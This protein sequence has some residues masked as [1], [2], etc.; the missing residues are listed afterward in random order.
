M[1]DEPR[2]QEIR[3]QLKQEVYRS[4]NNSHSLSRRQDAE[5]AKLTRVA[6]ETARADVILNA[7]GA[8]NP[9]VDSFTAGFGAAMGAAAGATSSTPWPRLSPG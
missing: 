1:L 4:P 7:N 8:V 9:K 5:A 3:E 2:Y 6:N